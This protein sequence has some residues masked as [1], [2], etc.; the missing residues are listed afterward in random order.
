MT[1]ALAA[2]RAYQHLGFNV[3]P[4]VYG[5]KTPAI[6]QLQPFFSRMAS[7]H[8]IVAW[9][10]SGTAHNMG[11]ITGS[12]SQLMVIDIDGQASELVFLAR[13][14]EIPSLLDKMGRTMGATSG[15][16]KHFYFRTESA[17]FPSG[18]DNT[19]LFNGEGGEIRVK[20]NRGYVIAP[21]SL[22]PGGKPYESNNKELHSVTPEEWRQLLAAFRTTEAAKRPIAELFATEY[23]ITVGNNRHEDLLRVMES[24]ISRNKGILTEDQIKSIAMQWNDDHCQPPL[25]KEESAKQ[26]ACAVRFIAKSASKK[27]DLI[28]LEPVV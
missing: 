1:E 9:F 18:V 16:G 20:G 2:A 21:P 27:N 11:I 24:L 17:E 7:E 19:I 26:W 6:N 4:V 23:K 28:K 13:V 25:S 22:H 15:K 12:I 10:G 8:E 3:V 5:Q 14:E